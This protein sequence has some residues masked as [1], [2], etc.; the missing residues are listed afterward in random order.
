MA[1]PG[2]T[3]E[4]TEETI[5]VMA[6]VLTLWLSGGG[7]VRLSNNNNSNRDDDDDVDGNNNSYKKHVVKGPWH[8]GCC[9]KF[10]QRTG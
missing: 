6:E 4:L 5:P 7:Q 1:G 9:G 10:Y 3:S 2:H 8:R